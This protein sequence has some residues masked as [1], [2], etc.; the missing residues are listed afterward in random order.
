MTLSLDKVGHIKGGAAIAAFFAVCF[1][2]PAGILLGRP[3]ALAAFLA[4][5]LVVAVAGGI[6]EYLDS[7]DPQHHSVE[8]LDFV[9]TVV[10]G[11]LVLVPCTALVMWLPIWS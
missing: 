6:K 11:L 4:T 7:L 10:G 8:L 2:V 5:L 9:A 3:G 1:G